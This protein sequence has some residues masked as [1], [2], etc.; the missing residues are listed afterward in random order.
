MLF[1]RAGKGV[2]MIE[3]HFAKRNF[4]RKVYIKEKQVS[5]VS[6]EASNYPISLNIKQMQDV[7]KGKA[8]EELKAKNIDVEKVKKMIEE[9]G[10]NPDDYE[11]EE[12]IAEDITKEFKQLGW[13]PTVRRINGVAG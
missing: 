2:R 8:N 9:N 4:L 5:M 11:S 7:T 10:I 1:L 6:N 12:A 3:L 13:R